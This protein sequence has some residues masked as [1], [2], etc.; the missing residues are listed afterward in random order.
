MTGE[1][2]KIYQLLNFVLSKTN[3]VLPG[4][5]FASDLVQDCLDLYSKDYVC[6]TIDNTK[7]ILCSTYPVQLIVPVRQ[8]VPNSKKHLPE[9]ELDEMIDL[10]QRGKFARTRG[11]FPAPVLLFGDKFICRSSTLARSPEIYT[12]TGYHYFIH[13]DPHVTDNE[14][15]SQQQE[16]NERLVSNGL[17][18]NSV[19]SET[20][21]ASTPVHYKAN[22]GNSVMDCSVVLNGNNH[23][24]KVAT[25]SSP[26]NGSNQNKQWLIDKMRNTDIDL[27][28]LLKTNV[29]CDFMVEKKKVK[30]GMNVTSSEKVDRQQRYSK[31]DLISF[32]YPGCEFFADYTN[33]NYTG[34]GLKFDWTQQF[35]D[36]QLQVPDNMKKLSEVDW[37]EYVHWDLVQLTQNYLKLLLNCLSKEG[38]TGIL[39]HC[40]SGW[41]RT[42]LFVSLLRL[43][44]W[45]D[46]FIHQSLNAENI[47]FLTLAYDWLLFS[48][49]FSDRIEKSEEIMRFCF[50]FLEHIVSEEFSLLNEG[51]CIE[52][53]LLEE[54]DPGGEEM[55]YLESSEND[56][57]FSYFNNGANVNGQLDN[58]SNHQSEQPFVESIANCSATDID[59]EVQQSLNDILSEVVSQLCDD[60][61]V[62]NCCSNSKKIELDLA[63]ETKA[64]MWQVNNN[65]AVLGTNNNCFSTE[66]LDRKESVCNGNIATTQL[67]ASVLSS[68]Y[69]TA[70]LNISLALQKKLDEKKMTSSA[71]HSQSKSN[72]IRIPLSNGEKSASVENGIGEKRSDSPANC[73]A[74]EPGSSWQM[75]ASPENGHQYALRDN[76][77]FSSDFISS[78]ASPSSRKSSFTSSLN[79]HSDADV[80]RHRLLRRKERLKAA[81]NVMIPA[82]CAAVQ[83]QRRK[84]EQQGTLSA[85][86]GHI[87]KMF[88][89]S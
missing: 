74:A 46:G 14:N 75:I 22:M 77:S 57:S 41:D 73:T 79:G 34:V 8:K 7:G 70:K 50:D 6:T 85:L 18:S 2:S 31:F 9:Y 67:P 37:K 19:Y 4:E 33:N 68:S 66:N 35:V 11:R 36:A 1:S 17:K 20:E 3:N 44:L 88:P 49:Q 27:L 80:L 16:S 81:K 48:H 28:C 86:M 45:A 54:K 64:S 29:I 84:Q 12:R 38:C 26:I 51:N 30:F 53:V 13:G 61:I 56:T 42:P 47:V 25:Q 60:V 55:F 43:S 32:P 23:K 62:G 76:F 21:A 82:Y 15:Q 40:I 78:S 24:R 63:N 10:I 58:H 72:P 83:V 39:L 71:Q 52:L 89:G 69:E 59:V 65:A 87:T 5:K